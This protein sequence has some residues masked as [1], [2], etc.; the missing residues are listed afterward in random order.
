M[1][2]IDMVMS[3]AVICAETR[4]SPGVTTE[5][6]QLYILSYKSAGV[7]ILVGRMD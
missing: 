7:P 5:S 6:I 4:Q 3:M 2:R 1:A